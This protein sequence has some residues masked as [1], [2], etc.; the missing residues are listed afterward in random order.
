VPERKLF[1]EVVPFDAGMLFVPIIM[2]ACIEEKWF[3]FS[4]G[5]APGYCYVTLSGLGNNIYNP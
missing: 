2:I 1:S 4:G 3:F 5:V